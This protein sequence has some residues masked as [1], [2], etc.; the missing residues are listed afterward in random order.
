MKKL[1][2]EKIEQEIVAIVKKV[3]EQ[4]DIKE[5]VNGNFCPGL[6]IMS[7]VLVSIISEIEIK[8]GLTIP[9]DCYIFYDSNKNKEQLSIKNAVK[10]LLKVAKNEE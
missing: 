2:I 4:Q 9:I 7:Q 3:C 8:T 10:K 1:D 6:F 5:E